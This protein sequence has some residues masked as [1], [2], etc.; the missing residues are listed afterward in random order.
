M[1]NFFQARSPAQKLVIPSANGCNRNGLFDFF[2]G[3]TLETVL[4]LIVASRA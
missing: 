3:R 4:L 2:G 1:E